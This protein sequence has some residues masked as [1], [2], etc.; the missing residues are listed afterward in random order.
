[1]GWRDLQPAALSPGEL[2]ESRIGNKVF[3]V[4][5]SLLPTNL[6]DMQEGL[7]T[8]LFLVSRVETFRISPMSMK[9]S[10]PR[11]R[12]ADDAKTY[13]RPFQWRPRD[14]PG[15]SVPHCLVFL[16]GSDLARL[17]LRIRN[18][19]TVRASGRVSIA[20]AARAS[21]AAERSTS[22]ILKNM[23]YFLLRRCGST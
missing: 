16:I 17:Y 18:K 8:T 15:V 9:P 6:D 1:M 4:M 20:P 7:D 11:A 19:R 2:G 22:E 14:G 21:A 13:P 3:L 23:V 10:A 12:R 5:S